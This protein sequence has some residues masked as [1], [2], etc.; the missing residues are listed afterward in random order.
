[1]AS[2]FRNLTEHELGRVHGLI[3]DVEIAPEGVIF[4][5]GDLADCLYYIESGTVSLFIEKFNSVQEIQEARAGDW[6]G[7]VA[8]VNKGYRTASA[9]AKEATRL[10]KISAADFHALLAQ[11][12]EIDHTIRSIVDARN[13]RLVLEE[14][15]LDARGY[16]NSDMH[17]SIK[18][19]ASLR[20]SAMLRAR[21]ESVVDKN[22]EALAACFVD[23]LVNRTAHRIMIGFNNG[24]IRVSTVLDPFSEEFHPA[25]RLL[26]AS[27]VERHFPKIDYNRKAEMIRHMYR[28]IGDE[29]F[30]GE[31]PEHLKHG[32][33]GYFDN[34]QPLPADE[35]PKIIAQLPELRKI[36]N[37]YARSATINI[38]KDAIQMQFNCDGSH[39]V[40][41]RAYERFVEDL[42]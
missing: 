35:I 2:I 13:E 28:A 30:F 19:D 24:E 33:S 36:S 32:F 38:V 6:F 41:A 16:G 3:S 18:G 22:L 5:E 37:F 25:Q 7:E 29:A 31:L 27:Y 26:D 8:V 12:P 17:V 40:S 10:G 14:K 39:I 21:Y 9:K 20:E 11:E 42:V 23:L 4:N 34:W 15:M 1:M